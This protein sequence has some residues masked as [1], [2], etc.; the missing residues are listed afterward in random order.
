M[1]GLSAQTTPGSPHPQPLYGHELMKTC[2]NYSSNTPSATSP[3]CAIFSVQLPIPA[4]ADLDSLAATIN[5][6]HAA[7]QTYAMLSI[8]KIR[9][10]GGTQPRAGMQMFVVDDY[11]EAMRDGATFPPIIAFYDGQDYWLADGFHRLNAAHQAGLAEIRADIRQGTRRDAILHSVG[12]NA[13]HGIRRTNDDKRRAVLTLLNDDEWRAWSDREIARRCGVS[14]RLVNGIRKELSAKDSQIDR[15]ATRGGT[16]YTVRTQNIGAK[17][18]PEVRAAIRDSG[19]V[20]RPEEIRRLELFEPKKQAEAVAFIAENPA[21]VKTAAAA[22]ELNLKEQQA[23]IKLMYFKQAL[24]A[25]GIL[26]EHHERLIS[27]Y[28]HGGGAAVFPILAAQR[29][30]LAFYADAVAAGEVEVVTEKNNLVLPRGDDPR[31]ADFLMM[32]PKNLGAP[33]TGQ[34]W[35]WPKFTGLEVLSRANCYSPKLYGLGLNLNGI[36]MECYDIPLF[37]PDEWE[38]FTDFLEIAALEELPDIPARAHIAWGAVARERRIKTTAIRRDYDPH[39][40]RFITADVCKTC[41]PYVFVKKAWGCWC[42]VEFNDGDG[43]RTLRRWFQ[44]D[45]LAHSLIVQAHESVDPLTFSHT[46]IR[47]MAIWKAA[48]HEVSWGYV[49]HKTIDRDAAIAALEADLARLQAAESLGA[50][51]I[52]ARAL[53]WLQDWTLAS[54][55]AR[56]H[57]REGDVTWPRRADGTV[58]IEKAD[59]LWPGVAR[60]IGTEAQL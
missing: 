17:L 49:R 15:K 31:L 37:S 5:A 9:T 22:R 18:T 44:H 27:A 54:L 52:K 11:A 39:Y 2:A 41:G 38:A 16:T 32:T 42:I 13:M 40:G 24:T 20:D 47:D 1:F 45:H 46:N 10:D 43:G 57:F 30:D 35:H 56:D 58:D 21:K 8:S 59:E 23:S 3:V 28:A 6:A 33:F 36:L 26:A 7:A 60:V 50:D 34:T 51:E 53:D 19:I 4:Q 48:P 12:A 14:D 29:P 55:T 25:S